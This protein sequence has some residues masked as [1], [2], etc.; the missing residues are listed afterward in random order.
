MNIPCFS[1]SVVCLTDIWLNKTACLLV[2][3]L[4]NVIKSIDG[5]AELSW[6]WREGR[7]GGILLVCEHLVP[8]KY[9]EHAKQWPC[10]ASSILSMWPVLGPFVGLKAALHVFSCLNI[11]ALY[12]LWNFMTLG[13][14]EVLAND[15]Q[16]DLPCWAAERGRDRSVNAVISLWTEIPLLIDIRLSPS[17][18]HLC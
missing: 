13:L 14:C 2:V 7:G 10:L 6:E 16:T 8:M 4:H 5:V 3:E 11:K 12:F 18:H 15:Y 1:N 17:P 9:G